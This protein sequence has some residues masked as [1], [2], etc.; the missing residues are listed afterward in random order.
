MTGYSITVRQINPGTDG[1]SVGHVW[2]T[3]GTPTGFDP[4]WG[5]YPDGLQRNDDASHPVPDFE[6]SWS[7]TEQQYNAVQWYI[8]GYLGTWYKF[9]WEVCTDFAVGALEAAGV[10]M[11]NDGD[12]PLFPSDIKRWLDTPNLSFDD[13]WDEIVKLNPELA[14]LFT[15]AQQWVWPRDP[16]TL[17][18]DGDGL[19]V[20]PVSSTNPILFDHDGDGIRNA[21][22]WI[23]ADDGFLVMDRNGNGAIDNGTELFGDSTNLYAGGKAAD[24]FAA[25]A[26]EDTNGDGKVSSA[27][28]HFGSLRVWRDL[29]QNGISESGEL[30]TLGAL[31]I[32]SIDTASKANNQ[33]LP[34]G[35]Q[36]ADLGT[37]TR[38]DGSTGTVGEV[39]KLADVNLAVDT[40][41][42]EF[43]DTVPLAA[44]ITALPN[45]QGSGLV[46]DLWEAMSQ[47]ASLKG[48]IE[49]FAA[50]TTQAGQK[51]LLDRIL[52]A[53]ADTSG[54]KGSP[55]QRLPE[56]QTSLD[57][58]YDIEYMQI[59]TAFRHQ[60]PNLHNP[61][62]PVDL[63]DL[64]D[65]QDMRWD[66]EYRALVTHWEN[67]I[68]TLEAF[69]GR[70]FFTFPWEQPV[71]QTA[72][73]GVL[74]RQAVTGGTGGYAAASLGTGNWIPIELRYSTQQLNLLEQS[75]EA[76]KDSIY[77]ALV[78]QT[79]LKPYLDQAQLVIDEAGVR[80]NFA[81]VTAAFQTKASSDA[82][83]AIADLLDMQ[84][85][86]GSSLL[87][88]GYSPI[89]T[90]LEVL[91]S[92]TVTP[93]I[94]T[95]LAD[96]GFKRL[97]A[98][99]A[100]YRASNAR[101]ENIIGNAL[102]NYI[103]GSAGL[104]TIDAG[105]GNDRVFGAAGNDIIYGKGGADNLYGE[106]GDDTLDGGAGNDQLYGGS[107]ADT[108]LFG[109]GS[110]QD[111][112]DNSDGDA[113]GVN[114]DTVLVKAN[115]A[116]VTLKRI[117]AS[118]SIAID[119]T[120]DVLQL[121]LYFYLDGTT[122]DTVE[123][124]RF[125]D[126]TVLDYATV[127]AITLSGTPDHDTLNG[128]AVADVM[129]GGEGNDTL[130]GSDGDD[131]MDG[132]NGDDVVSGD[133]GNDQITGGTGSDTLWGGNGADTLEGGA[134]ND[135]V[136]GNNGSDV[137]LFGRGHG[138]DTI[139]NSDSDAPG[140]NADTL[141]FADGILPDDVEV[142]REGNDL[143]VSIAGT[144]DSVRVQRYFESD[145]TT[146]YALE[147]IQ[148]SNGTNWDIAAVKTRV[149]QV[150]GEGVP[151]YGYGTDDALGGTAGAETLYGNAGND[152]LDGK[153]GGDIIYGG[154]G[155]DVIV[156]GANNDFMVGDGG[157]DTLDGG[158]DNDT[159]QGGDGTDMLD[160]GLGDDTLYGHGGPDTY[161]FGRGDG[162]DTINNADGD[163]L[164][165]NPDT[166]SLKQ[167]IAPADVRLTRS[168]VD[169]VV[170]LIGSDDSVRVAGYFQQE[171]TTT[172]VVERI[173]FA[174]GTV[175]T[176]DAVKAAVL[177]GSEDDD[178][179][180]GYAANDLLSGGMGRDTLMGYGGD[181]ALDGGSER[182]M[183]YGG[184]G[185]DSMLGGTGNDYVSGDAG[186]DTLD[187]G[188][189]D[190]SLYGGDGADVLDGGTGTDTLS[191][192]NGA[193][194]Y[195]FARGGGKDTVNNSDA[196]AV[197]T[198]A[199]SIEL[200]AGIS[201]T[202]VTLLRNGT[203][204]TVAINGTNDA[205][206]IAGHFSQETQTA[207]SIDFLKFADGTI[208]DFAAIKSRV[209]TATTPTS[210]MLYGTSGADNLAGGNG[211]QSIV[212]YACNDIL[213]G[214]A[215]D[216]SM[217]GG[218]GNDTYLFGRG[219]GK[220]RISSYDTATSKLD[221]VQFTA[222]IAPGDIVTTRESDDLVM[223]V[224]GTSDTLRVAS[225]FSSD[226][227]SGY[228]VEQIRFADGTTWNVATVKAMATVATGESDTLRG[229]AGADA[230]SGL[231]GDDTIYGKAGDDTLDGGD[232]EDLL[233]GEDG[234]DTLVGGRQIDTLNG[235]N[236]N[237]ALSG[238]NGNDTLNGN[239]GNDLLDGG[240]GDDSMDGGTGN[241]TYVFG[242]GAGK[243]RIYGLDNTAGKLDVVQ[244]GAG[245]LPAEV[246]VRRISDDL[247]ISI[248]GTSDSLTVAA[249]FSS[250]AT[251]GYQVE[252]IRFEDGTVWDVVAIKA[253]VFQPT[254]GND[255]LRGYAGA[256]S[257]AG[258]DGDDVIY[259]KDGSDS[260]DGGGGNDT[261]YGE[262]GDDTLTGGA[263][264]DMVYGGAGNDTVLGGAG[265]DTA[266]GDAGNDTLDGGAGND[267]LDG[268]A[269]NDTYL[270]GRGSG[271]DRIFGQDNGVGKLDVVQLGAGIAPSD[272]RLTR[273]SATLVVSINGTSDNLR[274]ESYFSNDGA[275]G[276]QVE[277]IRFAD[278][279]VLDVAAVKTLV[280]A[281]TPGADSL[282]GYATAD[283]IVGGD[284]DDT[285][286]GEA[287]ADTLDGG[288][289]NDYMGGED[290]DDVLR[291]G[292][293]V[294]TLYGGYGNDFL[295]GGAGND[296]VIDGNSG[297]D[298]LFGG[299]GAD[300]LSDSIGAGLF[301]GGSGKDVL[302][303]GSA[304]EIYIGGT[305]DDTVNLSS[306]SDVVLFNLGDGVDF[307]QGNGGTDDV[308]S[309]GGG[310]KF[311]DLQ[312]RK[313]NYDLILDV[314]DADSVVFRNWYQANSNLKTV[315]KLQFVH[316]GTSGFDAG[317]S[318]ALLNKSVQQFDLLGLV[319]RFDQALAA[320]PG[321]S[322]WALA[323]VLS[324]YHLGSSDTGALG[325]DI[326]FYY[327]KNA[328]LTG[329]SA[330]A[331]QD[332][333]GSASLGTANQA[334]RPFAGISGG[335]L[336]LS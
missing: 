281:S 211:N 58:R 178:T 37:Y 290:G 39:M 307:V 15:R 240:A 21:T 64:H 187:G 246:Q 214:G 296:T 251:G 230:I 274:I 10:P 183:M 38:T 43:P 70:Y 29:N 13:I 24:G 71:G 265:N 130:Y 226:G 332:V 326:A 212:A 47:S 80:V 44:G 206:A 56:P 264:N 325:G 179:L 48:M 189:G 127:K 81:P 65:S 117:G 267:T 210:T 318:N 6:K 242:R 199:D 35:N 8:N 73:T 185:A 203:L 287:G 310:V 170:S 269:G 106:Q 177:A 116:D 172:N 30:F 129:S 22:G 279:T 149:T 232:G 286:L 41:H 283:V 227:A 191:G 260:L 324:T 150:S 86:M 293:H 220:D 140:V 222:G 225:Y 262:N 68:H 333:I 151:L 75:Y 107:G 217:D 155:D 111:T 137:Y 190:D 74:V 143:I 153:A 108:Y 138:Q 321:L 112:I 100:D 309:I 234:N 19:E 253:M 223:T 133:N 121:H 201:T 42:R 28:A 224:S 238:G 216:D 134:G 88:M 113:L 104:D 239:A 16:M 317:S 18:L 298:L 33:P 60:H 2:I 302:T 96:A 46:R 83:N 233:Y 235:G 308:L 202:D 141:R 99:M 76:L 123:Q 228:Q 218:A 122:S 154:L 79:R 244:V 26:Q 164:G 51:A 204:L 292:D 174:D 17:D 229:Y 135:S 163:A 102:K 89:E 319:S 62:N 237:D 120:E 200:A 23:K 162:R 93:E 284:G 280:T 34:G 3:L 194:V 254:A 188:T 49:Q 299:T 277:Q 118:L 109:R 45:M 306:G 32:A 327:G 295:D 249:Y 243:D 331:A 160:G 289:G 268:G 27:D 69:N 181:D 139:N 110:G 241:D 304:A 266:N 132:G 136:N 192:G 91:D 312:F 208:W 329:M 87:Q 209:V 90:L 303:G 12:G 245:I 184:D 219:S 77:G 259:G 168:G 156:G 124:I 57:D 159:L 161:R 271:K 314:S 207:N 144:D 9:P 14:D 205:I 213:D 275:G 158:A 248:A 193:D 173:A 315:A 31:N 175:W 72:V 157:N 263:Q 256:D 316:S 186:A 145:A 196:D 198:H 125:E 313:E 330:A 288:A 255:T 215:G 297:N 82:Y 320:S 50:A 98:A 115:F 261:L 101:G 165:I 66:A 40:F 334:I 97:D 148:F 250:D 167:G 252:Q 63:E 322:G 128:Y 305:G 258:Q 78:T 270:F 171:G 59:G 180:S 328:N 53:W 126:G 95:L 282:T 114:A 142:R 1:S 311:G 291:G 278:G 55:D 146:T 182:D 294:D 103:Q 25:L 231:A 221:V 5:F 85:Y 119:G 147:S 166:L 257:L 84:R 335:N 169:L 131:T 195:R 236:G 54:L 52:T 92:T 323:N 7:I 301:S 36:I 4:S 276:Y 273:N 336:T 105:A 61:S 285:I 20:V 94:S 176:V 67:R 197:G 152:M 247:V 300:Y 272:V 11:V